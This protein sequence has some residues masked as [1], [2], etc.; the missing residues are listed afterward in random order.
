MCRQN[1]KE[2]EDE[3]EE[4]DK[5]AEKEEEVHSELEIHTHTHTHTHT[6]AKKTHTK[7]HTQKKPLVWLSA[8]NCA[9]LL[10]LTNRNQFDQSHAQFQHCETRKIRSASVMVRE[11]DSRM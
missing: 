5:E 3:G 9:L 8:R 1:D 4:E 6:H 7:T 10:C 2:E 11:Q